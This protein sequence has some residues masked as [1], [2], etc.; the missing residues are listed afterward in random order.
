M[1]MKREREKRENIIKDARISLKFLQRMNDNLNAVNS[2][3]TSYQPNS[4]IQSNFVV[5]CLD[6]HV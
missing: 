5:G 6:G 4:F 2:I 3:P 1:K